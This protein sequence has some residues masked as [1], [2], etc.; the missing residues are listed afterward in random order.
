MIIQ[1]LWILGVTSAWAEQG[2]IQA[3]ILNLRN[4]R[5]KV[6]CSI[7][8]S[9]EGFP[10]DTTKAVQQL[11]SPPLNKKA[12]CEFPVLKPG[13][14]AMSVFHDENE[15]GKMDTN[16]LGMP[17]EGVGSSNDA[18]GFMGP[19]SFEKAKFSVKQ[20]EVIHLKIHVVYL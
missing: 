6:H 5:G 3:E 15:S 16:F 9:K 13:D 19:P 18:K 2:G 20:D 1:I 12:L 10:S 8:S 17:T 4:D 11:N 14:Y 7:Y